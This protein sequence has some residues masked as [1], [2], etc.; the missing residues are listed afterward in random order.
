MVTIG[1][2]DASALREISLI[3]A[4]HMLVGLMAKHGVASFATLKSMFSSIR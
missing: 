1:S 4:L 2:G 3:M